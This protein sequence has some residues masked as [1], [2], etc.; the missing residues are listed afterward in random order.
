MPLPPDLEDAVSVKDFWIVYLLSK[1]NDEILSTLSD[2]QQ[3]CDLF[4]GDNGYGFTLSVSPRYPGEA[5][6]SFISSSSPPVDIANTGIHHFS[7]ALRWSEVDVICR[8]IAATDQSLPH[9]GIP[10]LFLSTFAPI[11][12]GDDVDWIASLVDQAL[13]NIGFTYSEIRDVLMGL[14]ARDGGFRWRYDDIIHDWVIQQYRDYTSSRALYSHRNTSSKDFP[15]ETWPLML[16]AAEEAAA[17]LGDKTP[18]SLLVSGKYMLPQKYMFYLTVY[19]G[20][21]PHPLFQGAKE[22]FPTVLDRI[23][24]DLDSGNAF[25]NSSHMR[26]LPDGKSIYTSF[27]TNVQF[28]CDLDHGLRLLQSSLLWFGAPINSYLTDTKFSSSSKRELLRIR[29]LERPRD[30][31]SYLAIGSLKAFFYK[32]GKPA[33][34]AGE[35][36]SGRQLIMASLDKA[37][38]PAAKNGWRTFT[39]LDGGE[40]DFYVGETVSEAVPDLYTIKLRRISAGVAGLVYEMLTHGKMALFPLMVTVVSDLVQSTKEQLGEHAYSELPP[41]KELG[42]AEELFDILDQGPYQW[43]CRGNDVQAAGGPELSSV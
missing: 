36:D 21:S 23:L 8:A 2:K 22:F 6:L 14:D 17:L 28:H 29:E 26:S 9:P 37:K 1:G 27:N 13:S 38:M 35:P 41:A 25:G 43:W 12:I 10:L 24:R 16:S 34:T 20:E 30:T 31:E 15:F 32:E 5:T 39:A 11:C 42:S 4:V 19:I 33:A 3:S 7:S 18:T 40:L